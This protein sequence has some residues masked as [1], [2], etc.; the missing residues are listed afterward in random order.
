MIMHMQI[1]T[2]SLKETMNFGQDLSKK[3]LG[4]NI[5]CLYG[6]LGAGKTSLVKGLALGFGIKKEITS[7]TFALMNI[8]DVD[9]NGIK[10]IVHIDTYRLKNEEELLDIGIEDFLGKPDT[11]CIIEWPEKIENLLIGKPIKTVSIEHGQEN[12]RKILYLAAN[13]TKLIN[14][15]SLSLEIARPFLGKK[16][17]IEIDRPIGTIHKGMIYTLNYGFLPGVKTPDGEDLDAYYL[18]SSEPEKKAQGTCIAIIHRLEDDDDKL[19]I[20]NHSYTK[21]EIEKKVFFSEKY[22]LHEIIV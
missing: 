17:A 22:F 6:E 18:D 3:L 7:P 1:I 2:K 5:L 14:N 16:V 9:Q 21:E 20:S 11:L 8:Y 13:N 19:V 10:K 15:K 12:E 4:G